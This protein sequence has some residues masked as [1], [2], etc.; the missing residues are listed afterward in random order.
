MSFAQNVYIASFGSF[1]KQLGI[2]NFGAFQS[3]V[4]LRCD[5]CVCSLS[6]LHESAVSGHLELT[7]MLIEHGAAVDVHDNEGFII[8]YVRFLHFA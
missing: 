3:S 7:Q 6:A 5:G 1:I 8:R 4:V 2:S